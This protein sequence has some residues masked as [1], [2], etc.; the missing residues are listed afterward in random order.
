MVQFVVPTYSPPVE[1]G[2]CKQIP[3]ACFDTK[4]RGAGWTIGSA[5]CYEQ[6]FAALAVQ[7]RRSLSSWQGICMCIWCVSKM[8]GGIPQN[9]L[10][11]LAGFLKQVFFDWRFGRPVSG[12][13]IWL[14]VKIRFQEAAC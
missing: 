5:H 9:E 12:K 4:E 10:C 3:L 13:L 14:R 8:G 6:W 7:H 11:S 2:S 1:P